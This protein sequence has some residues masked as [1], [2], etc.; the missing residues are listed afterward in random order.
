MLI[1]FLFLGA[2]GLA[3]TV[4][5]AASDDLYGLDTARDQT[6]SLMS[7]GED[8][9]SAANSIA[10]GTGKILGAFLAFLGVIFLILMI[11]AGVMWMTAAGNEQQ[12]AK[13][14]N[15]IIAA[16]IG[17]IIVLAAYALTSYLGDNI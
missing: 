4:T 6:G 15:L 14:R 3:R 7:K 2:I 16:V 8:T 1:I 10:L 9:S 13:A 17:L 12:V 5:A 11:Y